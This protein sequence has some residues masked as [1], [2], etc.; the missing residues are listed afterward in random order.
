MSVQE[1]IKEIANSNH[2]WRSRES[3]STV[4]FVTFNKGEVIFMK[5]E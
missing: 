4:G 1:N 2:L 3:S 5:Y